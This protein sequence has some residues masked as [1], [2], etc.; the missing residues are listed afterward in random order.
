MSQILANT[1]ASKVLANK[2]T[3]TLVK[4]YHARL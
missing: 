4:F 1:L 2:V 3:I